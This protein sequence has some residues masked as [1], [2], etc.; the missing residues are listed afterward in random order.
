MSRF[1]VFL[2]FAAAAVLA[3]GLVFF[4]GGWV[5]HKYAGHEPA[6]SVGLTVIRGIHLLSHVPR[7]GT[8]A[9]AAKSQQ[10]IR[11]FVQVGF[12]VGADGRAHHIHVI[13][14]EPPGQYEE[15]AREII[16]ARHFKPGPAGKKGSAER[17]EIV[18]FQAPTSV[19]TS[20]TA[21][22]GEGGG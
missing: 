9:K 12:T 5:I 11:G 14:A 3:G 6:Q 19:L 21:D 18:H 15:A 17:T 13:S 8:S 16:A 4:G 22:N 7:Q 10:T 1:Y 20:N 2:R